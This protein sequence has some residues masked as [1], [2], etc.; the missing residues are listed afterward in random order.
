MIDARATRP[1][2]ASRASDDSLLMRLELAH[3]RIRK[4][5]EENAELRQ[6]LARSLG[7]LRTAR[8]GVH[9][10]GETKVRRNG[11]ADS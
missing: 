1:V 3:Q 10:N 7:E 9:V 2:A 4:L 11:D 6:Q 8:L 5:S